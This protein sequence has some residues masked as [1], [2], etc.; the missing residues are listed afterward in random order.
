MACMG[1]G[2]AEGGWAVVGPEQCDVHPS[3][4]TLKEVRLWDAQDIP[5][6]ARATELI[7]RHGS[8]AG[9]EL[10]HNGY[11]ALN[12][13]SREIPMAPTARPVAGLLPITAR[14]MDKADIRK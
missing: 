11:R 8:L 6:L 5:Y 3:G 10:V 1:G 7:H 13:E 4:S 12:L 9:V 2:K 14:A